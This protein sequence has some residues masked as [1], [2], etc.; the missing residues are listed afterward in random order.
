MDKGTLSDLLTKIKKIPENILGLIAVQILHG[1]EYLHKEM[2][3][4]HRDIKHSNILLNSEGK[5]II[6][7]LKF[8]ISELQVLC[9]R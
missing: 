3:V 4:I 9:P 2:K 5:V 7:R 6:S 8:Q 1:L